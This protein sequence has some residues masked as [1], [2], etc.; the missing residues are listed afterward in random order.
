MAKKY[1]KASKKEI[2][3]IDDSFTLTRV[4]YEA[5]EDGDIKTKMMPPIKFSFRDTKKKKKKKDAK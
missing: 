5:D 4:T 1:K 3:P 2:A